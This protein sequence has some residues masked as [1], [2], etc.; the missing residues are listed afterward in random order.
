MLTE[1]AHVRAN[2]TFGLAILS[3]DRDR[4]L[5]N[6]H[7]STHCLILLPLQVS[8]HDP[9]VH[10]WHRVDDLRDPERLP[11]HFSF[12]VKRHCS[13][14]SL[15]PEPGS[16]C[17]NGHVCQVN[18]AALPSVSL[19]PSLSQLPLFCLPSPKGRHAATTALLSRVSPPSLPLSSPTR[20]RRGGGM[21]VRRGPMLAIVRPLV[22][23]RASEMPAADARAR[24]LLPLF[25]F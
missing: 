4:Q 3:R 21:R 25:G 16:S 6:F 14:K 12:N 9:R 13:S 20:Y 10:G 22:R 18:S 24:C 1:P 17:A 5:R 15:F 2:S 7:R 8:R 19:P 11:T 23:V